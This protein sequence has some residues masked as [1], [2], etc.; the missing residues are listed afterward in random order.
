MCSKSCNFPS[1]QLLEYRRELVKVADRL[2]P[3]SQELMDIMASALAIDQLRILHEG[4]TG[5][6]CWY[7][8]MAGR[9]AVVNG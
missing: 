3:Q 5:C 4:I 7:E 2:N 1:A 8:A 9:L 6:Q